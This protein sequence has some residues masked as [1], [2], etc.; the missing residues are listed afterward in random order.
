MQADELHDTSLRRAKFFPHVSAYVAAVP[1]YV[2]GFMTLGIA[3]KVSL[4]GQDV[5]SVRARAQAAGL[6]GKTQYWTPEIHV[7][8]FNLPPYIARHLPAGKA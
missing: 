2:G 6:E 3:S 8:S 1:T 5:Q 7:G 4:A